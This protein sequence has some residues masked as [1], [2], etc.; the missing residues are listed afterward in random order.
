M[1]DYKYKYEKYKTKYL[2]IKESLK[3]NMSGGADD[4]NKDNK[5][6]N[7]KN[8]K[9]DP[10]IKV[11]CIEVHQKE[12]DDK[13]FKGELCKTPPIKIKFHSEE[14]KLSFIVKS[15]IRLVNKSLKT[16]DVKTVEVTEKEKKMKKYDGKDLSEIINLNK[17]N[18][19][20]KIV[21][22]L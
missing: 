11:N 12:N 19:Y 2:K 22:R 14:V 6:N 21:I 7:K 4:K 17:K 15:L 16:K 20:D 9:N 13:F 5:K 1:Q 10:V 8:N 18:N 3:N